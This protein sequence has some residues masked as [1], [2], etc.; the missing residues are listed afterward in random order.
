VRDLNSELLSWNVEARVSEP[1]R[2]FARPLVSDAVRESES[3][4]ALKK[5]VFSV[6]ADAEVREPPRDLNKEDFSARLEARVNEPANDRKK[7]FFSAIVVPREIVAVRDLARPLVSEL[8]RLNESEK[9]LNSEVVLE[10]P[11]PRVR[12]SVNDRANPLT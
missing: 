10:R 12:E 4:S 1:D 5:E 2:V 6:N 3:L 7:E 11:D 8:A 9:D